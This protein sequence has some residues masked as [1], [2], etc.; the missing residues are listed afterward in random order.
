MLNVA[1][2]ISARFFILPLRIPESS[3]VNSSPCFWRLRSGADNFNYPVFE[4]LLKSKRNM[5]F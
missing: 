1:V 5:R 3:V 4:I 2:F